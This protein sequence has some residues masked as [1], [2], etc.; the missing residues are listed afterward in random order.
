MP[1]LSQATNCA[2]ASFRRFCSFVLRYFRDNLSTK[3]RVQSYN[4]FFAP[5]TTPHKIIVSLHKIS[6][7]SA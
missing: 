2:M 1:I 7:T 3:K 6:C 5:T 4:F